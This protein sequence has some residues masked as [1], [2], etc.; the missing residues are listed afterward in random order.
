MKDL[1]EQS[2]LP[3]LLG[4]VGGLMRMMC[5]RREGQKCSF[6]LVIIEMVVAAFTGFLVDAIMV[7]MGAS[8]N[9]RVVTISIAG[10]SSREVLEVLCRTVLA[11]LKKIAEK[12]N[13]EEQ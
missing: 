12:I 6:T 10:F 9:W 1:L 7:E 11:A 5:A 4:A 13:R 8:P 2:W 3:A